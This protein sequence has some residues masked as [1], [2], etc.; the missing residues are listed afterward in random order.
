MATIEGW[1][2]PWKE[3]VVS[4]GP[5]SESAMVCTQGGWVLAGSIASAALG[6]AFWA[7]AARLF[8]FEAVGLAG[9]LVGLSSLAT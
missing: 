7:F 1:E 8:T 5:M 3:P 6:F 2:F 9:S 4:T